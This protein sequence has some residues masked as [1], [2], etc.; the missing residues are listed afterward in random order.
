MRLLRTLVHSDLYTS[1]LP[2][3]GDIQRLDDVLCAV[4]WSLAR[5]PNIYGVVRGM[6]GVRLLKTDAQNDVPALR[7]WFRISDNGDVHLLYIERNPPQE[8]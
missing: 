7:I 3:L 6:R 4:E 5:N 8:P 1:Q 2:L